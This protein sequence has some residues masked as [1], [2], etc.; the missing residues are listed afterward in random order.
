MLI[1]D[2]LIVPESEYDKKLRRCYEAE[3]RRRAR[4]LRLEAI[5]IKWFDRF[6][7]FIK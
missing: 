2:E 4:A 3:A 6:F 1:D 7:P 5:F